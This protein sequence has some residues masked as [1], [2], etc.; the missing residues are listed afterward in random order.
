MTLSLTPAEAQAKIQQIEDARNQAV[1]TLQKIEDSQQLM[2]GSAWKGGSATAYGH[3]SA[4]QNDDINQ[5][6]NNLNQIV[7]TASAQIRSV[8]NMD[9]N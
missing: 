4:T 9:N 3:T 7:E 6:I 5:I 1:A 8:A 2:L